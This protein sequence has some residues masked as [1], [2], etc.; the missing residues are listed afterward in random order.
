MEERGDLLDA[1]DDVLRRGVE[2]ASSATLPSA[3][4]VTCGADWSPKLVKV[5]GFRPRGAVRNVPLSG[6][7]PSWVAR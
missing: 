1:R 7:V 6:V 5:N 3:A 4:Q 2:F